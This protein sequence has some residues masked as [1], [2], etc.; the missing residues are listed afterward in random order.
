M[1]SFIFIFKE[2]NKHFKTIK[3]FLKYIFNKPIN[4]YT[5]HIIYGISTSLIKIKSLVDIKKKREIPIFNNKLIF[6]L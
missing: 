6:K 4:V 1:L 5:I 2:K 3:V